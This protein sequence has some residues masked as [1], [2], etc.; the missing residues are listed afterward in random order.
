MA[1]E[2]VEGAD[3]MLQAH[4]DI[5]V[6]W[7]VKD[8]CEP[9]LHPAVIS[10][11]DDHAVGPSVRLVKHAVPNVCAT[12]IQSVMFILPI[13]QTLHLPDSHNTPPPQN[14]VGFTALLFLGATVRNDVATAGV[15]VGLMFYNV[16]GRSISIGDPLDGC[17]PGV[18]GSAGSAHSTALLT[19]STGFS[20]GLAPLCAQVG[21]S[22][23]WACPQSPRS[24]PGHFH[25]ALQA[26]GANNLMRVGLLAQRGLIRQGGMLALCLLFQMFADPILTSLRQPEQVVKPAQQFLWLRASTLPIVAASSVMMRYQQAQGQFWPIASGAFGQ[27]V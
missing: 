21:L 1:D 12:V 5:R 9:P 7:R 18:S 14:S 27:F 15:G 26:K 17:M 4:E 8:E 25:T 16:F 6:S 10:C 20:L 19:L 22:R 23:T 2:A 13:S 11:G 24:S 3:I